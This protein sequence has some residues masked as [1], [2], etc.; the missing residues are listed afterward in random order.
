MII[1]TRKPVPP[2]RGCNIES[3][4]IFIVCEFWCEDLRKF[5]DIKGGSWEKLKLADVGE[6]LNLLEN[7]LIL[8]KIGNEKKVQEGQSPIVQIL[9]KQWL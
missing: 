1:P 4:T 9:L 7:N 2:S 5:H 3:L 8:L 6:R